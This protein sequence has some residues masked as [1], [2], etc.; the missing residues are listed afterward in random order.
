[1]GVV[2]IDSIHKMFFPGREEMVQIYELL[3]IE[4]LRKVWKK[5]KLLHAKETSD[6]VK[7]D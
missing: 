5:P 6:D 2:S 7:P 3:D 1:M 4:I